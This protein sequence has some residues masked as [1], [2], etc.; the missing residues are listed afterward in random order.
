VSQTH[1]A[2]AA[3]EGGAAQQA[4]LTVLVYSSN[5]AMRA[6]VKTSVGT[7]PVTDLGPIQWVEAS[8]GPA[9]IAVLDAGGIDLVV[10]DGEAWPTG[11]MGIARQI[12]DEYPDP[13]ATV[14]L[15]ARADDRWLATWSRAD[16]TVAYP[17]DPFVL[18]DTLVGLLRAR[19]TRPLPAPKVRKAFGI[20]VHE[21]E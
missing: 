5:H 21:H 2:P 9:C 1:P 4:V 17:V 6:R 15:V 10:L 20:R 14:L 18:T 7:R 11:G 19:G 8:D 16:A 13:P 3:L 12:K